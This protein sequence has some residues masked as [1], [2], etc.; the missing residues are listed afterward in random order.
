MTKADWVK[1]VVVRCPECSIEQYAEEIQ[2]ENDLFPTYL[3][4]C[5]KCGYEIMESEWDCV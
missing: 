3:H 5:E 4:T 1:T 2:Y